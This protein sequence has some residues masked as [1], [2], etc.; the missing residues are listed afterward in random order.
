M[1]TESRAQKNSQ[2][3][4]RGFVHGHMSCARRYLLCRR[5]VLAHRKP[6]TE[7]AAFVVF[8]CVHISCLFTRFLSFM[9]CS[10]R[11]GHPT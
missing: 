4:A 3:G 1:S 2:A 7:I 10:S 5:P 8:A 6:R 11:T 9:I